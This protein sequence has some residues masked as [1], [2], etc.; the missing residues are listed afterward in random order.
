MNSVDPHIAFV[1]AVARNRV[2]GKDNALPWHLPGEL[3]YFKQR[4]WG[5][6]V[7]MGRKT[8]ASIGRPLPGR[9]NLVVSRDPQLELAGCEVFGSVDGAV[10]RGREIARRDGVDEVM[11]I[12]GA[13]IFAHLLASADI[14]YLTRVEADVEGDTLF[15]EWR[16]DEWSCRE[17]GAVAATDQ[18]PPYTL[19]EY[20]R[21][22]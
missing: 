4:T 6:P 14:L 22:R 2:I 15:P 21:N 11:V 7:I 9:S 12:G 1:V 13:E 17:L 19:L 20:R 16:E 5:R 8:H 18:A 10:R 3:Q